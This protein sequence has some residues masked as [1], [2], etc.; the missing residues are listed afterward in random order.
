MVVY[1]YDNLIKKIKEKFENFSN[2]SKNL[3]ITEEN[4]ALK[5]DNKSEFEQSEIDKACDL[6]DIDTKEINLYF[7]TYIIQ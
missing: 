5:L 6:L 4:L 1:N 7:F 3:G 2:F